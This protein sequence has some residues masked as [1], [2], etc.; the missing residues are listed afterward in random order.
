MLLAGLCTYSE[1]SSLQ[2][3][4]LACLK[5]DLTLSGHPPEPPREA[6]PPRRVHEE[7]IPLHLAQPGLHRP[8]PAQVP[9]PHL[10]LHQRQLHPRMEHYL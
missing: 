7:Q 6:G 10:Q 2:D 5:P 4:L 8:P 3:S 9:G 1:A